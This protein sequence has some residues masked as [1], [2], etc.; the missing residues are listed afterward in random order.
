MI[1]NNS[2]KFWPFSFYLLFFAGAAA[3]F[4][5][6]A[7]FFQDKGLTGSQIGVL[8]G[9]SSIVGLFAGPFWSSVAD[10]SHRHRLVLSA[11]ILG[12]VIAIS[13]Y[14]FFNLFP[15]FLLLVIMAA[16]FGGPVISMVDN[17]AMS[18][19][20]AERAMYGRVRLGGTIGWGVMA[21]LMG[22][23]VERYGL[24]WNFLIYAAFMLLGLLVAQRLHFRPRPADGTASG[25][26]RQ[27]LSDRK[28]IVFLTIVFIAGSGLAAVQ[29]YYF[30]YL[31]S[32]GTSPTWMGLAITIATVAEFPA[33]FFADRLM[34]RLGPRGL[35]TLGLAATALRC[36]L[37]GMIGVP[38]MALAAQVSQAVTFPIL[39]VAG[40]SY[41]DQNAPPGMGATAQS[42]FTSAFL[43]VGFAAGGFFGGVMMD[44]IGV[45]PMFLV[46]GTLIM[47]A[48]LIFSLV[49]RREEKMLLVGNQ[50]TGD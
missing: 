4:N 44:Y 19:L 46:F 8:L 5:F 14:P 22:V 12:N 17:A 2:N 29:A 37:Y 18:M 6:L 40:V 10:A 38:W 1:K 45:R 48:A 3:V 43:G 35:L 28:W 30:I 50:E 16:L 24:R 20:G 31:E 21:A 49:Q 36:L 34:R 32:I 25:S 15:V 33:L 42:I 7:L 11:A 23:I 27:L 41:A 26:L 39:L 47:L 13:L 9:A